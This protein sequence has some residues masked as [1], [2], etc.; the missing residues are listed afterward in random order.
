MV[1]SNIICKVIN[2]WPPYYYEV[3]L[4]HLIYYPKLLHIHR[5]C[6]FCVVGYYNHGGVVTLDGGGGLIVS[7]YM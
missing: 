1:F 3:P 4:I 6:F 7:H 2:T 5:L